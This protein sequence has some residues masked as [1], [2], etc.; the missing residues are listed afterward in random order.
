MKK[1]NVPEFSTTSYY[2][3]Y[4]Y[5]LSMKKQAT[6]K[7]GTLKQIEKVI[8]CSSKTLYRFMKDCRE[9]GLMSYNEE[10]CS[11]YMV[12]KDLKLMNKLMPLSGIYRLYKDKTIVYV[13]KSTNIP[14]R[15]L[16][17]KSGKNKKDFDSYDYCCL[18]SES[19]INLYEVYYICKLKPL[20]NKE[21][22]NLDDLSVELPEIEFESIKN[23]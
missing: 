22:K 20:M 2:K 8:G 9:I 16:T 21:S 12:N 5:C 11:Y 13:G 19:D 14:T 18:D 1:V 3:Y 6:S 15:I 4:L 17:H 7:V 10:D 23:I